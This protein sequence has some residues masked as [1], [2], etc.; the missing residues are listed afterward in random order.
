MVEIIKASS[1]SLHLENT[2][3][4]GW[5]TKAQQARNPVNDV[6]TKISKPDRAKDNIFLKPKDDRTYGS[7]WMTVW[8]LDTGG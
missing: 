4:S 3:S 8:R 6:Q 7:G 2:G 5:T 1:I